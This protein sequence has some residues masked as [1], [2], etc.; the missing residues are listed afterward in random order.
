M[1]DAPAEGEAK[2]DSAP[3]EEKKDGDAEM[4]NEEGKAE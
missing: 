3:A 2:A 4:K 1:K